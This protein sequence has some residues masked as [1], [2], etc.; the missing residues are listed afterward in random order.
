MR[1]DDVVTLPQSQPPQR[2]VGM[3]SAIPPSYWGQSYL[4]AQEQQQYALGVERHA[5]IRE[6]QVRP[7]PVV[8]WLTLESDHSSLLHH[9]TAAVWKS[10]PQSNKLL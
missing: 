4:T 6:Q 2:Q 10:T 5:L 3:T 9:T 7:D 1:V 8:S